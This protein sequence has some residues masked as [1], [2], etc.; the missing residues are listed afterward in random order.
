MLRNSYASDDQ[1][2]LRSELQQHCWCC[3]LESSSLLL[4]TVLYNSS[5]TPPVRYTILYHVEARIIPSLR[6]MYR[7]ALPAHTPT[8]IY[9][10]CPSH[11]ISVH[12]SASIRPAVHHTTT[13][14]TQNSVPLQHKIFSIVR[15]LS[16]WFLRECRMCRTNPVKNIN[17]ISWTCENYWIY[18]DNI[19]IM[20][21]SHFQ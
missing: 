2:K 3:S 19:A 11:H 9:T 13:P 14:S 10:S 6:Y 1:R 8:P 12:L 17:I 21:A 16:R 4:H 18:I 20:F 15:N 5:V 7:S